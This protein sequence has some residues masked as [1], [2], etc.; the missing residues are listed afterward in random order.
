MATSQMSNVIQQ[1]H[2]AMLVQEAPD[3]QLLGRVLRNQ[4]DAED[5]FLGLAA[6]H[7]IH[8]QEMANRLQ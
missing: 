6:A 5:A 7:G 4:Q 3:G 2:K 8:V 1:L